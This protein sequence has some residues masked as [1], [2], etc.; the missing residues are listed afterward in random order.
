L[1]PACGAGTEVT[2]AANARRSSEQPAASIQESS[3]GG[4]QKKPGVT[5]LAG[6]SQLI[7]RCAARG[8]RL[9]LAWAIPLSLGLLS[10]KHP[11][12]AALQGRD[13]GK[14][15]HHSISRGRH[16]RENEAIRWPQRGLL[17]TEARL[18]GEP[19][20]ALIA[21]SGVGV[22]LERL[23]PRICVKASAKSSQDQNGLGLLLCSV[24]R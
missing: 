20:C 3:G 1:V 19:G 10:L 22:F 11:S 23:R 2:V 7:Y 21:M 14:L 16:G 24:N 9:G 15:G 13:E 8:T 18:S 5:F 4:H 6:S 17:V 12:Q